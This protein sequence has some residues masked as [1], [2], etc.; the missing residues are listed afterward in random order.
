MLH[1]RVFPTEHRSPSTSIHYP[2][3]SRFVKVG[4]TRCSSKETLP[5]TRLGKTSGAGLEGRK[6]TLGSGA[7][8]VVAEN[9]GHTAVKLF[10]KEP[11]SGEA[12]EVIP[13]GSCP[14]RGSRIRPRSTWTFF[15]QGDD[16]RRRDVNR[17]GIN[18]N[19]PGWVDSASLKLSPFR[20]FQ[21][22]QSLLRVPLEIE[23]RNNPSSISKRM[24]SRACVQVEGPREDVHVQVIFDQNR[25][26]KTATRGSARHQ[27]NGGVPSSDRWT[28]W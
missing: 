6:T 8:A 15:P 16:A 25:N 24:L 9:V 3:F 4:F 23:A 13:S 11:D 1:V 12:E 18:R 17:H 19:C 26:E 10:W 20:Q 5:E 21:L 7:V 22:A 2:G 14:D 28:T 27:T